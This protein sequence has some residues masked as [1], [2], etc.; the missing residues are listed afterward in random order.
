M[1][2][3]NTTPTTHRNIGGDAFAAVIERMLDPDWFA[4]RRGEYRL[5]LATHPRL[6]AADGRLG[7]GHDL[8]GLMCYMVVE[9]IEPGIDD[10]EAASLVLACLT[11]ATSSDGGDTGDGGGDGPLIQLIRRVRRHS[12]PREEEKSP[13]EQVREA[14]S[15]YGPALAMIAGNMA[16]LAD[17]S[18]REEKNRRLAGQLEQAIGIAQGHEK[19]TRERLDEASRLVAG[20]EK[21]AS[22]D[23][24][25]AHLLRL[26]H[27][28]AGVYQGGRVYDARPFGHGV[29][30]TPMRG[31]RDHPCWSDAYLDLYAKPGDD[32]LCTGKAVRRL[33]NQGVDMTG[34]WP[35]HKW[36]ERL[37]PD[38]RPVNR[39]LI[40]EAKA[41][42]EAEKAQTTQEMHDA[43]LSAS[44]DGAT[45]DGPELE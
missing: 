16:R 21:Q 41:R 43:G 8:D 2:T 11:D 7:D 5:L 22:L 4:A 36:L 32:R 12:Q 44:A 39:Q 26:I 13:E 29:C 45:Y 28:L 35:A 23:R 34:W 31:N 27:A 33:R 9:S 40:A 3:T 15:A 6:R 19:R 30:E 14:I 25:T 18:A 17:L 20:A 38:I 1:T 37:S 10:E 42:D 24:D